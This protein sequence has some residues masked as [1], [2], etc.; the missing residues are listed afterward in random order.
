MEFY[1]YSIGVPLSSPISEPYAISQPWQ[2]CRLNLLNPLF[3]PYSSWTNKEYR[4][5]FLGTVS[6]CVELDVIN[7][8][9]SGYLEMLQVRV[10]TVTLTFTEYIIHEV[11]AG[12][13]RFRSLWSRASPSP[14]VDR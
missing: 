4:E 3:V 2:T 6:V 12:G 5:G 10:K 1:L 7:E 9:V 14:L 13:F 8:F 11:W